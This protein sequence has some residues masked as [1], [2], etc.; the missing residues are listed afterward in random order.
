MIEDNF[1]VVPN[2]LTALAINEAVDYAVGRKARFLRQK[3][4]SQ[5]WY[6]LPVGLE[7]ATSPGFRW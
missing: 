3:V 5:D 1:P 6:R 2:I 4:Y 7:F